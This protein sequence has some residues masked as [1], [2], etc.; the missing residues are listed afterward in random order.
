MS[1]H[2][3]IASVEIGKQDYPFYGLLM[4]VIRKA[5]SINLQKL[6][7][8]WPHLVDEFHRR[9]NAPGGVLEEDSE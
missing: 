8:A 7:F 3:Y 5:D 2:E 1:Y 4:A 9:Y 6:Q